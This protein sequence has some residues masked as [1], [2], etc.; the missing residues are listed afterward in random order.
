MEDSSDIEHQFLRNQMQ[1]APFGVAIGL[2]TFIVNN[3]GL[4]NVSA[5]NNLCFFRCLAVFR[6]SDHRGCN[7]AAKK[8]FH[9]YCR[10]FEINEF[11]GINLIDFVHL[12]N[13]Y[14]LN[15]VAYE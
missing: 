1:D 12:E 9:E 7:R 10:G 15:I 3:R 11:A 13:F 5:E 8:L 2:P 6:G 14:Q 4:A